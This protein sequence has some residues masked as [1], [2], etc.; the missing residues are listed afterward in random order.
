MERGVALARGRFDVSK[1]DIRKTVIFEMV[2]R[3]R[4]KMPQVTFSL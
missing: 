1:L 3:R 4:S 2:I